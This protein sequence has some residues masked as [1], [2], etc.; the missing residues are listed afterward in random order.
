[1]EFII[2]LLIIIILILFLYIFTLKKEIKRIAKKIKGI[3]SEKTNALINNEFEEKNLIYL[4]KEINDIVTEIN[5][6]ESNMNVKTEEL[7]KMIINTAH[8]LRTPLTSAIGYI[9]LIQNNNISEDK[10]EKYIQIISERLQKLSYLITNL[11]EYS[12]ISSNN[13]KIEKNKE[14]LIKIIED[15]IVNFYEDFIKENRKINFN[16]KNSKIEIM[17]DKSLLIRAFDNMII[18]AYKHSKSDLDIEIH[19]EKEKI[20]VKFMNKLEDYD[21]DVNAIFEKFY[22]TDISR[23]NGNTGLGLAIAKDFI[24]LTNGNVYAVKEDGLLKIIVTFASDN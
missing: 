21:L 1:M 12:K 8:D 5:K 19:Q 14:N 16:H 18:N 23:T 9:E 15:C 7:K 17:T 13:N 4:I 10:K 3:R 11:F 2:C 24:E 20:I 22:T 6:R